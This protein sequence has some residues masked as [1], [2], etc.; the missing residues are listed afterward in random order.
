MGG[1]SAYYTQA[2][3]N[4][5]DFLDE[6]RTSLKDRRFRPLPV[7]ERLI[8]TQSKDQEPR[9]GPTFTHPSVH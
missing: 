7:R 8:P 2:V 6:L 4:V 3:R 5:E 9:S 1:Q